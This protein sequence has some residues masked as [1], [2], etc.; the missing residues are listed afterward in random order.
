MDWQLG[1][2]SSHWPPSSVHATGMV[3]SKARQ[4]PHHLEMLL[5]MS[6]QQLG[7]V[8]LPPPS[9]REHGA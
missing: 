2:T 9:L 3:G 8:V 4:K 5:T 7:K 1:G 6:P